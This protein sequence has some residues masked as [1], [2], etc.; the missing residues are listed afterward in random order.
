MNKLRF[1]KREQFRTDFSGPFLRDI[2]GQIGSIGHDPYNHIGLNS[3]FSPPAALR[4]AFERLV[5]F[6]KRRKHGISSN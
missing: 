4:C 3:G 5:N 6:P 1:T 2:V